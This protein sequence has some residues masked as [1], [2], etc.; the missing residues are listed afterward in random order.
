MKKF[1]QAIPDVQTA[2][3]LIMECMDGWWDDLPVKRADF[4]SNIVSATTKDALTDAV[5]CKASDR[6]F[7]DIVVLCINSGVRVSSDT[8]MLNAVA[9]E[10]AQ[11]VDR[12]K[13]QGASLMF[14]VLLFNAGV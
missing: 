9:R 4:I 7:A 1:K 11:V 2:H 8:P 12:L 5:L 6:G 14:K 10:H 3:K 13:T